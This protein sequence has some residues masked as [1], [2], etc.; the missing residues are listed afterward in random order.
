MSETPLAFEEVP[1]NMKEIP[2]FNPWYPGAHYDGKSIAKLT[3]EG[4]DQAVVNQE[5]NLAIKW[6][7]IDGEIIPRNGQAVAIC[8]EYSE[9]ILITEGVGTLPFV[10]AEP[11]EHL[12]TVT[13]PE[14]C[15]AEKKVMVA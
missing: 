11:G 1:L 5:I 14:G 7:G 8:G 3:L 9:E 12:I 10:S 4:S 6:L 15:R 13:S 2:E